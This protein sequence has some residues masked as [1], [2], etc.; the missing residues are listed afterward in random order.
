MELRDRGASLQHVR[1]VLR[2]LHKLNE[3]PLRLCRL[4]V[5]GSTV[6]VYDPNDHVLR[7]VLDNQVAYE[8]I[9][10]DSIAA[11]VEDAI[12]EHPELGREDI[13]TRGMRVG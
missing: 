9:A 3:D 5:F 7:R 6:H 4:V 13:V 8:E 12:I 1:A 11:R 10:L 2:R